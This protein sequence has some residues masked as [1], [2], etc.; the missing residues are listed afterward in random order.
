MQKELEQF[1]LDDH[2][3]PVAI[4]DRGIVDGAAYWPEGPASFYEAIG[5]PEE[6]VF[7]RYSTVIHLHTPSLAMGYDNSNPMRTETAAQAAELD[8]RIE[9]VWAGH[10]NRLVVPATESFTDKLDHVTSLIRAELTRQSL[11]LAARP[12]A[13][14]RELAP[15]LLH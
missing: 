3:A 1:T 14:A 7:A 9:S 5:M 11:P 6:Q 15:E 12:P 4:C 10:P 8:R 2:T 13:L